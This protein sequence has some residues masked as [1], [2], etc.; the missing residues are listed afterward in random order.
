MDV[1]HFRTIDARH[2]PGGLASKPGYN[3][4]IH[5]QGSISN[6][7]LACIQHHWSFLDES[8]LAEVLFVTRL[9][10]SLTGSQAHK[11]EVSPR[12]MPKPQ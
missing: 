8:P 11:L 10:L 5:P 12:K 3:C 4:Y 9:I 7:P 1:I 6:N 2:H